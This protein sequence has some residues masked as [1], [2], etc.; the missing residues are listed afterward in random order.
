MPLRRKRNK[1]FSQKPGK[2]TSVTSVSSTTT[3][4]TLAPSILPPAATTVAGDEPATVAEVDALLNKEEP[5]FDPEEEREMKRLGVA[6]M[7][8]HRYG[9]GDGRSA[10]RHDEGAE[11]FLWLLSKY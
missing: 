7:F 5:L 1:G 9:A 10:K 2:K 4:S 8:V 6:M 3:T 11:I